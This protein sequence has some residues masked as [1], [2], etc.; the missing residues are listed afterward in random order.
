VLQT[1]KLTRTDLALWFVAVAVFG[2]LAWPDLFHVSGDALIH[3]IYAER[4][5]AGRWFQ[6]NP[7]ELSAGSTSLFYTVALTWLLR[8]LSL[9][10]TLYVACTGCIAAVVLVLWLVY[11]ATQRAT[12]SRTWA[13]VASLAVAANPGLTYNAPQGIE[14][15]FFAAAV[16]ALL[17]RD[18]EWVTAR[19]F[20]SRSMVAA[21]IAALVVALRPEGIPVLG[22]TLVMLAVTRRAG[23]LRP[24]VTGPLLVAA[25]AGAAAMVLAGL[26]QWRWTGVFLPASA[27]S[28]LM[29]A[30]REGLHFG[31]LWIYPRFPVRLLVYAPLTA[32]T[33]ICPWVLRRDPTNRPLARL[34]A[35]V[36]A[37]T[38]VLY[39]FVTGAVHV[40]RYMMFLLPPMA[41]AAALVAGRLWPNRRGR[42]VVVLGAVVLLASYG[43]ETVMRIRW[44]RQFGSST[45]GW[46]ADWHDARVGNTNDWLNIIGFDPE[47]CGKMRLSYQEVQTGLSFDDRVEIVSTD[48]R[49]WPV[50]VSGIFR[51]DG[52]IDGERWIA[53]LKPNVLVELPQD[54][55]IVAAFEMCRSH[56]PA[57]C[58]Y[59][60]V[61]WVP[62]RG[63]NV[64]AD[65]RCLR[66]APPAPGPH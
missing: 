44:R 55:P 63:I 60:D 23:G 27:Y 9:R 34:A 1:G 58:R 49:I 65:R 40:A 20:S 12:G 51:T 57:P 32:A 30:R 61:E 13:T 19:T 37:S 38:T 18:P 10:A 35:A 52:I 3:L 26:W 45:V 6:F 36:L 42:W 5:A 56:R 7:G 25:G 54:G 28:R 48:G 22:V 31:G 4:A 47:K 11:R 8:W 24:S 46:L 64:W 41:L 33:I 21:V 43:A 59:A 29:M 53:T 14:A 66:D 39:T 16:A 2:L 62:I 15:P 17:F 50:G